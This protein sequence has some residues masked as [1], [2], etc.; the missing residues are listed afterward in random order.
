M[1]CDYK[2]SGSYVSAEQVHSAERTMTVIMGLLE[3]M[4]FER[5]AELEQTSCRYTSFAA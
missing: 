4:Y 1:K 2:D 3:Q 5:Q